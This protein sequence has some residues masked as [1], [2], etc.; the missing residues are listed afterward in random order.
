MNPTPVNTP[1]NSEDIPKTSGMA[2]ASMV[3]GILSILGLAILLIPIALAIILGH[4]SY[5]KIK[6]DPKLTGEGFAIAGFVMGYASIVFGI[7]LVGLV[8]AMAIPAFN[9]VRVTSQ[10]KMLQNDARQICAASDQYFLETANKA[11]SFSIDPQTGEI[12]GPLSEYLTKFTPGTQEVDG[13]VELENGSFSLT[14]EGFNH[15]EPLVFDGS[16][17]IIEGHP[18]R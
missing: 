11:V 8:T 13:T 10:M 2:I 5:S 16:A 7:L 9:K 18:F 1:L 12:S 17:N 14:F 4:V 3:I 6:K 15:G